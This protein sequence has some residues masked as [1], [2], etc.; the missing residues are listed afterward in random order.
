MVLPTAPVNVTFPAPAVIV[1]PSG[2][3]VWLSTVE[4]NVMFPPDDEGRRTG[5]VQERHAF[6]NVDI[7]PP[8]SST[9]VPR[10]DLVNRPSRPALERRRPRRKNATSSVGRV[11]PAFNVTGPCCA[12]VVAVSAVIVPVVAPPIVRFPAWIGPSTALVSCMSPAGPLPS[13]IVSF[14]PSPGSWSSPFRSWGVPVRLTLIGPWD[15]VT[16][17][18]DPDVSTPE[19]SNK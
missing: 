13:P 1:N 2:V 19:D 9:V 14:C 15:A 10:L 18:F 12:P 4:E 11:L 16:C 17:C 5:L 6:V 3:P 8:W 7:A